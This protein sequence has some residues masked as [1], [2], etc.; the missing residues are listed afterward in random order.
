M[1]KGDVI[2][3]VSCSSCEA[4]V[5]MHG[6]IKEVNEN[7][8]KARISFGK[9][10]PQRNRPEWFDVSGLRLETEAAVSMQVGGK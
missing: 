7:G 5:G 4:V 3:V 1:K 6:R 10:R 2:T 9:G 8:D